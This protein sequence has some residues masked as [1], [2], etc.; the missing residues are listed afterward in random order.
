MRELSEFSPQDPHD[1]RKDLG[2]ALPQDKDM[3]F[4]VRSRVGVQN[5]KPESWTRATTDS[6]NGKT[7]LDVGVVITTVPNT[8]EFTKSPRS[9]PGVFWLGWPRDV[10]PA[11]SRG[12]GDS[13][14]KEAQ[15]ERGG[16]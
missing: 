9:F 7:R 10:A 15:R 4:R 1:K 5:A 13:D 16:G 2:D 14:T 12:P 3:G 11:L 6:N 8:P